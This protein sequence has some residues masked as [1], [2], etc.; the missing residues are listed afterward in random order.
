[1]CVVCCV[2]RVAVSC[3]D[4]GCLLRVCCLWV[5]VYLFVSGWLLVIGCSLFVVCGVLF[6][7]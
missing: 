5:V 2:L 4:G 7:V 3:V 1:M 6:G